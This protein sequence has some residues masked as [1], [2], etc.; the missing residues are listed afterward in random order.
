MRDTTAVQR[1]RESLESSHTTDAK[2]SQHQQE[3]RFPSRRDIVS[4]DCI[5]LGWLSLVVLRLS[6][7]LRALYR[8]P[9][10]SAPRLEG[11]LPLH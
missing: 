4:Y 10:A 11:I 5:S 6:G 2:P 3:Q 9:G 8:A 7:L 1:D